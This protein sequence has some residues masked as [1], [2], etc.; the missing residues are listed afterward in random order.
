MDF[1]IIGRHVNVTQ[2]IKD[3]T[4]ARLEKLPR[5]F[6][7]IHGLKAI[8]DVEGDDIQVE[9]IAHL[10]KGDTVVAKA[11][12]RDTYVAI[13]MACDKLETQLRRYKDKLREHRA[14]PVAEEAPPPSAEE[15]QEEAS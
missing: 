6:G 2:E 4:D 11:S 12:D 10:V 7:R 3:Y 1:E 9:F 15:D 5:F 13:D 8:Y 14:K